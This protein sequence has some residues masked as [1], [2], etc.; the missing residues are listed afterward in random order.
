[1][2]AEMRTYLV[3]TCC[4]GG[5]IIC[6]MATKSQPGD[7]FSRY[8]GE[9]I[10]GEASMRGMSVSELARLMSIDRVTLRRYLTGERSLPMPVLYDAARAIGVAPEIIV[11]RADHRMS[12]D[13]VTLAASD[14]DHSD[15][16]E[17]MEE[18]P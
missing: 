13:E 18:A 2:Q 5:A 10:R 12:Q 17:G 14:Y 15:E 4:R 11:D 8:V 7:R 9:Q 6:H 1:M 3:S 16:V